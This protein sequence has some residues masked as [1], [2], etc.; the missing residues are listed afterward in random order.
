MN[1]FSFWTVNNRPPD[2]K[3]ECFIVLSYAVLSKSEPTRPTREIIELVFDWWKKFPDSFVIMST[4]DNQKLGVPNSRVMADYARKLGIKTDKIIEEDRSSDTCTNLIQSLAII[5]NK[6]FKRV[7][8]VTYDLH[9]RR[10][11]AIARKMGMDNFSY[12]STGGPGGPAY[13]IKTLQTHSR[14]TIFLYEILAYGYNFLK[15]EL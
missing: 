13:G 15:G 1:I 2:G 12:I 10:T 9:T 4:G 5:K 7:T 14:L 3:P 6:K 8:L 11:L